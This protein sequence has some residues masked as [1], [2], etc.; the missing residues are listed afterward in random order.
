MKAAI[1]EVMRLTWPTI[2]IVAVI[3]SIMR[4][5]YLFN[6]DRK[7]FMLHKELYNLIFIIY[8]LILFQLVTSQ[9]LSGGGTNLTPFKEIL[10]YKIGSKEFYKQV[11]GNII[12]FIPLGYF[13]SDKC[14]IKKFFGI[15]II[16]LVSST[17]IEFVQKFIGRSFDVDDIILNVLGGIC[18]YL[19]LVGVRAIRNRLPKMFKSDWFYNLLS[20]IFIILVVLYLLKII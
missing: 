16:S 5:V 3:I 11:I 19:L 13:A 17:T 12:L 1:I 2:A 6:S 7:G 8:I 4:I 14:K 18:G 20:I 15:T 9:D 10:R